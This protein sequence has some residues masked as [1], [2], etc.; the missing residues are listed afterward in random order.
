MKMKAGC[1]LHT[2]CADC[3]PLGWFSAMWLSRI[4]WNFLLFASSLPPQLPENRRSC[5]S[6]HWTL[7]GR[8]WKAAPEEKAVA[9]QP[10]SWVLP[11]GPVMPPARP[12]GTGP[13]RQLQE[14]CDALSLLRPW[15][16]VPLAP[17]A[18]AQVSGPGPGLLSLWVAASLSRGLL[19]WRQS[20]LSGEKFLGRAHRPELAGV[21]LGSLKRPVH[22]RCPNREMNRVYVPVDR[23]LPASARD[24]WNQRPRRLTQSRPSWLGFVK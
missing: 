17:A 10:L 18:R 15:S 19:L 21:P 23:C 12:R 6:G 24:T 8:M 5:D 9:A 2:F 22:L 3:I 13:C 20:F 4:R 7:T 16:L 14:G 1:L 11:G